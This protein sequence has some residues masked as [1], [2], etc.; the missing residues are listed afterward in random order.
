MKLNSCR[1]LHRMAALFMSASL[2]VCMTGCQTQTVPGGSSSVSS[3]DSVSGDDA[4]QGAGDPVSGTRENTRIDDNGKPIYDF[5]EF[6]NG[7]WLKEREMAGDGVVCAFFANDRIVRDRVMDILVNTDLS[8]LSE[9]DG[10]YKAV[11][12]QRLRV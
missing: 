1:L 2:F 8:G 6:V 7:E 9:D 5:D 10:L 11:I 3:G 12:F 4:G